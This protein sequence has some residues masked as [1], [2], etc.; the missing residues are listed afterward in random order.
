MFR[1]IRIRKHEVGLWFRRGDFQRV[2]EPGAHRLADGLFWGGRLERFNTLESE[3]KHRLL[4]V[5]VADEQVRAELVLVELADDQRALVWKDGR[6]GWVLKPGRHAFWKG[7]AKIEVEV[8][9]VNDVKFTHPKL[10]A[11]ANF[12]TGAQVF[13]GVRVESHERVLL[14]ADGELIDELGAGLHLF[15]NGGRK[16]TWK[17]VDLREQVADVAG[18]EIMTADKVTLRVNLV[19]TY[20]VTDPVKA[21]T[22]VADHAQA[23]Y[24]EAQLLL[25]EAVGGRALEKLL[26]DKDEV[27]S[28]VRN[29]LARRAETFGV[30]VRGVGLRD[31]IL[32]GEMKSILNEVIL[33][34][35]QAEANLIRRREDTAAA[36]SEANTAKLLAGNPTLARMRE[37]EAIGQVLKGVKATFVLGHGNLVEQVRS[38][39]G[40]GSDCPLSDA[41]ENVEGS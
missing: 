10:E 19:V 30:A 5:L 35:K 40:D 32:P 17:E 4:D 33:A 26:A 27:G 16:I 38:L 15:W 29:A 11:I 20:Q 28:E 1:K 39:T 12:P 14:F 31:I 7:P 6:L 9:D 13:T 18:Q 22:V 37:L 25:R 21:V 34:A 8:F 41:I 2:L 36:R 3:F 24:R 23:L